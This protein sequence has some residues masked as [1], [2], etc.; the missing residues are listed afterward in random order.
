MDTTEF[1]D[2]LAVKNIAIFW[3]GWVSPMRTAAARSVCLFQIEA[4]EE[5]VAV[6]TVRNQLAEQ[7]Y[8]TG[9]TV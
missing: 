2:F 6:G 5:L 7:M 8:R 1:G 4:E 9:I 3:V